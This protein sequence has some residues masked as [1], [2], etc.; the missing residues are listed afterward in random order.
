M[1]IFKTTV[2]VYL[3]FLLVSSL[4]IFPCSKTKIAARPRSRR[5]NAAAIHGSGQLPANMCEWTSPRLA[6]RTFFELEIHVIIS[7]QQTATGGLNKNFE[8]NL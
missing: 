2:L 4:S 3:E 1:R 6:C 5:R 7:N 8:R